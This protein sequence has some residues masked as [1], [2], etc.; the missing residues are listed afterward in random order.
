MPTGI[1]IIGRIGKGQCDFIIRTWECQE[2][3][4]HGNHGGSY[5][6]YSTHGIEASLAKGKLGEIAIG[7]LFSHASAVIITFTVN[8]SVAHCA[9]RD[10]LRVVQNSVLIGGMDIKDGNKQRECCAEGG[11]YGE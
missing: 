9:V 1:G 10:R 8:V 6:V 4:N 7:H 2:G 3:F 5:H 11:D